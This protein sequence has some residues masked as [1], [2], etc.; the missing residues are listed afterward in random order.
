MSQMNPKN[1]YTTFLD[2]LQY[3]AGHSVNERQKPLI[4]LNR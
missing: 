2:Q 1:V 3:I 4:F